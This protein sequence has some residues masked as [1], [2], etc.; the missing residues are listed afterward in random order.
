MSRYN[1]VSVTAKVILISLTFNNSFENLELSVVSKEILEADDKHF[2]GQVHHEVILIVESA[3]DSQSMLPSPPFFL[4]V[5]FQP[6]CCS[7]SHCK[8]ME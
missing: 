7:L 5:C 2:A 3:R 8:T 4:C 6:F 1:L